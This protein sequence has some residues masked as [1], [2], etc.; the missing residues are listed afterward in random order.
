MPWDD[1][2]YEFREKMPKALADFVKEKGA[3]LTEKDY[4][5]TIKDRLKNVMDLYK[6]SRYKPAPSGQYLA[7]ASSAVHIGQSPFS[8]SK[9]AGGTGDGGSR[10]VGAESKG[11]R[12][13]EVGNIYHLFEK[14]DGAPSEKSVA[15]PFPVVKWV[16][17]ETGTRTADD[18][19]EDKAATYIRNQNTLL[20]NA[21][22]RRLTRSP[23]RQ[24][25]ECRGSRLNRA[26]GQSSD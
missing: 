5:G 23:R 21:D 20:I 8:G 13:G 15:D 19:M 12:D 10:A 9:G 6:V 18:G 3:A 17:I 14:K 22:S 25:I 1:W 11:D 26:K 16:S 7:D 2:A 4:T 24:S